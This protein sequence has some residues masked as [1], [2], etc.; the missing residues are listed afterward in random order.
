VH[1]SPVELL[2]K[3]QYSLVLQCSSSDEAVV[4][5]TSNQRSSML[6]GRSE[7]KHTEH[8]DV[9]DIRVHLLPDTLYTSY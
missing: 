4:V 6:A 2:Q 8:T 7:L 3:L 5:S 1:S 9:Y